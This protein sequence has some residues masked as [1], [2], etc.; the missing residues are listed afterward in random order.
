M[1]IYTVLAAVLAAPAAFLFAACGSG[2]E[3][4]SVS[5]SYQI[6]DSGGFLD[7]ADGRRVVALHR[8]ATGSCSFL[9]GFVGNVYRDDVAVT[10]PG[11]VT[12]NFSLASGGPY[13]GS[14]YIDLDGSG[15]LTDNDRVWGSISTDFDGYCF[16]HTS[17]VPKPVVINWS[18]FLNTGTVAW[19]GGSQ[20]YSPGPGLDPDSGLARWLLAD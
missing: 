1:R 15:N 9:T 19:G 18:S 10:T 13:I 6:S 8:R 4:E 14:V 17:L 16:S 7:S 2:A 5:F 11:S 20:P 12:L 3:P